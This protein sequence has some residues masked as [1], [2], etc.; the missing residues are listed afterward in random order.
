MNRGQL[1][2]YMKSVIFSNSANLIERGKHQTLEEQI[3][4]DVAVISDDLA[5]VMLSTT[6]LTSSAG[7]PIPAG[8]WLREVNVFIT[9]GNPVIDIPA[10]GQN[11][12]TGED[13]YP[14]VANLKFTNAGTLTVNI[15][16]AGTI[17]VQIVKFNV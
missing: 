16:G 6:T 14:C 13:M 7:I 1:I 10:I 15:T 11:G 17:K 2:S 8:T 9:S 12:M 5:N 4:T 3:L